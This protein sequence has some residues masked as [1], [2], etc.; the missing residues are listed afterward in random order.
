[1]FERFFRGSA[2]GAHASGSGLGLAIVRAL[3]ERWGGAVSIA[4]RADGGAR[5]EV[6][7]PAG[8][9]KR[10]LPSPDPELDEAL[11]GRG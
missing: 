8:P 6:W 4:N 11:P 2:A 3:A 10:S 1:M 9:R 5:A 7:L